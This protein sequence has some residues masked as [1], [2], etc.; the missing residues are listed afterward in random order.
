ML[1]D[2]NDPKVKNIICNM[3]DV[4]GDV[5]QSRFTTR[6]DTIQPMPF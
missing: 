3:N 5:H 4:R 2:L 1:A 6:S